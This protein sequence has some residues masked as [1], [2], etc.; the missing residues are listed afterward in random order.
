MPAQKHVYVGEF[1][2]P[3]NGEYQKADTITVTETTHRT[4]RIDR[5]MTHAITRS[6]LGVSNAIR[7]D[8]ANSAPQEEAG[9]LDDEAI[10]NFLAMGIEE[11]EVYDQLCE[12]IRSSLT[13]K[14]ELACIEG[15]EV[16]L[17]D[18]VWANIGI[19]GENKVLSVFASFFFER[20]QNSSATKSGLN[21]STISSSPMTAASP[22][23]TPRVTQSVR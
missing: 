13:N 9:E 6:I 1:L 5:R 7:P 8:S 21:G 4:R 3:V 18:E 17:S 23:Q 22:S 12:A 10:L 14:P 2:Y 20:M 16:P 11:G 15:T 19:E